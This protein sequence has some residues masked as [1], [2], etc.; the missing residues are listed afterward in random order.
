MYG[1]DSIR[2]ELAGDA[3]EREQ[4]RRAPRTASNITCGL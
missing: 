1:D 4:A 3:L 2:I